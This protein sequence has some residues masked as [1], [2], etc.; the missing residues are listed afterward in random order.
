MTTCIGQIR[1]AKLKA[2]AI[3]SAARSSL[4]PDV[5]TLQGVGLPALD[6]KFWLALQVSAKTPHRSCRRCA[7]PWRPTQ[8]ATYGDALV[9]RGAEPF[10]MAP[11][12]GWIS[13]IGMQR[14][15]PTSHAP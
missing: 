8:D 1:G 9:A 10:R 3:T 12:S 13:S 14:A 11:A 7:K 6:L 15:G 4:L 2:L 5:P